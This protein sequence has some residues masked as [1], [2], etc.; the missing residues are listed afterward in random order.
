[1]PDPIHPTL[2]LRRNRDFLL[3]QAGQLLSTAGTQSTTIA[4][5]LLVLA[6]THSPAKA[7]IVTF[8]RIILYL[9]L[10]ML[11]GVAGDRW[12]RKGLMIAADGLRVLAIGSLP[13]TIL[14]GAL[15]FW[16]IPLVAF[17]EGVG[18]VLFAAA[19]PGALRSVVPA[20]QMPAA[21]ATQTA[22]QSVAT[23]GTT[24][25][26]ASARSS[27]GSGTSSSRA[28]SSRSS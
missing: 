8:A 25:S 17:V 22:R 10:S 2:P 15:V 23:S 9:L 6:V 7:G 21:V 20:P 1:M 26:C 12:N 16:Q 28:C 19:Q 27:S 4:Y 24:P 14:T 5:P 13:A 11:A 18:S 3:L